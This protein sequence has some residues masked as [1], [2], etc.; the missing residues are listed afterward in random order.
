MINKSEIG[1][2]VRQLLEGY[3]E[4]GTE[5][6]ISLRP[7]DYAD[8]YL[9]C[10]Y[11]NTYCIKTKKFLT[12]I[13]KE[14][15]TE[16]EYQITIRI[17][18]NALKEKYMAYEGAELQLPATVYE[19]KDA[20]QRA[21][22]TADEENYSISECELYG[23]DISDKLGDSK[24][25]LE[26]LNYLAHVLR[27]FSRHEHALFRGYMLQKGIDT[28]TLDDL[29]NITYNLQD[30]DIYYEIYDDVDLGKFYADNGML[31]WLC[32]VGENVW[33]YLNYA[34]IGYDIRTKENGIFTEDGYFYNSAE[35]YVQ[36]Y[37]GTTFPEIFEKDEY[38]F[39]LFI[40]PKH[41]AAETKEKGKWLSLPTSKEG[42]AKF[43]NELGVESYDDCV[44]FAVQS[45]ETVIPM[46][47]RGLEQLGILNALAHRMRDMDK[48]GSIPEFKAIIA[49][50]K[51]ENID[52][53]MAAADK[54]NE[55]ELYTE[56]SSL[57]EYAKMMYRDKYASVL[58]ESFERHFNFGTY[59]EEL[60]TNG[61]VVLTEY[62]V[63]K[64]LNPNRQI[65][66]EE[67]E[68]MI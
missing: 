39:K 68:N 35:E 42:K 55:Y 63:L 51:C 38:I 17:S 30:C 48:N 46:L 61:D 7:P 59:S 67:F 15:N 53:V 52:D 10:R 24:A 62:G 1:R 58:P 50:G 20:F 9:D 34:S 18:S 29:I 14:E 57:I 5:L 6:E 13:K 47:V 54:L 25:S 4:R 45:M 56:P 2:N 27:R 19:I 41:E 28:L 40:C 33:K 60:R 3:L 16:S 12:N 32:D 65:G 49:S 11:F 37:D 31:D 64:D 36:I 66:M 44:L 26:K 21:R 23:Q 43:L 8:V 22:M